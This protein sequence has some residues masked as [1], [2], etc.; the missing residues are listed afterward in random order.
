MNSAEVDTHGSGVPDE[1]ED[2][3]FNAGDFD[4]QDFDDFPDIMGFDGNDD[5]DTMVD[6]LVGAGGHREHSKLYAAT[7]L[8]K[9]QLDDF[10]GG[11]RQGFHRRRGQQ[12][13][14]QGR[15]TRNWSL[16]LENL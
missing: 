5:E 10:H 2:N 9:D 16:G 13:K 3:G 12:E 6:A 1:G 7:L 14:A 8:G 4:R 11:V 15:R